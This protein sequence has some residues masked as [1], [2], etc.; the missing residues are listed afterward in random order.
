MSSGRLTRPLALLAGGA[1]IA[2]MATLSAC[3]STKSPEA[4]STPPSQSESV[5]PSPSGS[6]P[7][8]MPSPT[9][10][11]AGSNGPNSFSPTINPVPPG[12]VCK[13]VRGNVCIR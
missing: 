1:A 11:A 7:M 3:G 8:P 6:M 12:A 9:E 5:T 10:K 2:G 4:P 13:E